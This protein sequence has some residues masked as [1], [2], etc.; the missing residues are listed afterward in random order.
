MTIRS[1]ARCFDSSPKSS[2]PKQLKEGLIINDSF[3]DHHSKFIKIFWENEASFGFWKRS[4]LLPFSSDHF[5]S[6]S[7]WKTS[8]ITFCRMSSSLTG[9]YSTY[10]MP[11]ALICFFISPLNLQENWVQIG[12]EEISST[13]SLAIDIFDNI[14]RSEFFHRQRNSAP[15]TRVFANENPM[16]NITQSEENQVAHS[17]NPK[18]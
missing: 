9:S 15:A 5:N 7:C 16:T 11:S 4:H 2:C 14:V 10:S 12:I 6:V 13:T 18:T 1:E 17:R 3:E 8:S